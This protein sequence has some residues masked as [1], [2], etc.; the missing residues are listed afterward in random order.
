[1][2]FLKCD[3][4]GHCNEV[5]TE[6]L[7]F[8]SNC[9][10]KLKN[11]YSDW[12]RLNPGKTFD[13]FKQTVCITEIVEAPQEKKER[14]RPK[15][16]KFWIGFSITMIFMTV[17]GQLGSEKLKGLF[18]KPIYDKALMEYANEINKNCPFMVDNATRLDNTIAL[19][20]NTFQY[21]YT[22]L[23]LVR[24]SVNVDELKKVIEPNIVNSVKTNPDMKTIRDHKTNINY[25]YKDR[26]GVFL[27]TISVS[28]DKYQ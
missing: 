23:T 8:C 25:Y 16:L 9:H 18:N 24:D 13:N 15:S 11:N 27:F 1:M 26:K 7:T 14:N 12:V 10:K 4:C 19:P 20:G 28:P 2:Y 6:Y 5:K 3:I 21:N 22:V 17:F